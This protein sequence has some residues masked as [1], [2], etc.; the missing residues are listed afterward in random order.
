MTKSQPVHNEGEVSPNRVD[1]W[2]HINARFRKRL[3]FHVGYDAGFFSEINNMVLAIVYCL[4]HEIRFML[5]SEDANFGNGKGWTDI[6]RPFCD[7]SD[8]NLHHSFNKRWLSEREQ[9]SLKSRLKYFLIKKWLG[10]DYFTHD[11][12]FP[13]RA[14]PIEGPYDFPALDLRGDLRFVC[15]EIAKM[16]F[17]PK[18][19][20][21]DQI[22]RLKS[23]LNLSTDY[24]GIHIR[25][26]DKLRE[27]ALFGL[28]E[29]MDAAE[30]I[31]SLRVCFVL[32]DDFAMIDEIERMY[33]N[34]QVATLCRPTEH[35]YDHRAHVQLKAEERFE[36][37]IRLIASMQILSNARHFIGTYS[38]NPGMFLGMIM[39][40]ERCKALDFD[41]WRVW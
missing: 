5:Y 34:W 8:N 28:S 17:R 35:G 18:P 31:S 26:G 3:V 29:Y 23:D 36:A 19:E 41:N 9:K 13:I 32:T 11:L 1:L 24:I 38:T 25:S 33:E 16:V 7:E 30:R 21:E 40:K 15:G 27:H 39:E 10:I 37:I 2:R 14:Q 20:I 22:S 12:W 4:N 6:F